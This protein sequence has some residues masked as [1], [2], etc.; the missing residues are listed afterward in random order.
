[1]RRIFIFVALFDVILFQVAFARTFWVLK[2]GTSYQVEV[3][4]R[5]KTK[6]HCYIFRFYFTQ[7]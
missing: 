1:M 3:K 7:L 5:K 4:L 6:T 2:D